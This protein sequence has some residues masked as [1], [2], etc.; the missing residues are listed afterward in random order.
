MRDEGL[1]ESAVFRPRGIVFG[2]EAY[3]DFFEKCAVLGYALIQN[4]PFVDGNKRTGFA[5][6]HLMLLMNG[7][8]LAS[9]TKMEVEM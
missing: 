5:S 1:L 3:P 9:S 4:H 7:Y 2:Q 8:D 6:M